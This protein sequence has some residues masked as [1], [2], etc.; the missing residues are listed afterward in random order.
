MV[1]FYV[2]AHDRKGRAVIDLRK[3]ELRLFEG[4]QEQ[5]IKELSIAKT[6][7]LTVGLLLD[8]SG[9]RRDEFPGAEATPAEDFSRHT[10]RPGD[11]AFVLA[12]QETG[13]LVSDLTDDIPTLQQAVE[14]AS[15]IRPHGSTAL[16][17]SIIWA[18]QE[19]LASRPG[20]KA[21]IIVSD[22]EDNASKVSED[23][24]IRTALSSQT[25]I[26]IV[27][28][29]TRGRSRHAIGRSIRARQNLADATGGEA[30]LVESQK[31]LQICFVAIAYQLRNSHML[32]YVP[33]GL[34]S[35]KGTR[36]IKLKSKRKGVGVRYPKSVFEPAN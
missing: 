19:K 12:F 3:D 28:L 15:Q 26:W 14:I 17:G 8:V 36:D 4:K 1:K 16:Y 31:D 24:A 6:D 27:D 35:P 23:A 22:V 33:K 20:R 2:F 5:E 11:S 18:C 13:N 21:L 25:A 7:P 29:V 30:F 9:S 32:G 34:P 10:L